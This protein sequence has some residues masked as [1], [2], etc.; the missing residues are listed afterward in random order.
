MFDVGGQRSERKK[1]IHCF[2]NLTA[3]IFL[4]ALSEYDQVL[5]EDEGVV[6][7]F[8]CILRAYLSLTRFHAESDA[9][10]SCIIRI[11]M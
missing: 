7:A 4:V 6:R 2:E 5:R 3:V 8:F 10:V 11:H 1:W 9:G